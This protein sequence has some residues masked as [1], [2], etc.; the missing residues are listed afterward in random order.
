LIIPSSALTKKRAKTTRRK[1]KRTITGLS[2]K[3]D[4]AKDLD[5]AKV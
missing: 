1:H 2:K 3:G 4:N 5:I